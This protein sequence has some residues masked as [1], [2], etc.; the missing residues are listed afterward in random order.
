MLQNVFLTDNF[1]TEEKPQ[2]DSLEHWQKSLNNKEF[3]AK[4]LT[5]S[6]GNDLLHLNDSFATN[7]LNYGSLL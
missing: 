6:I 1:I 3:R 5:L 7:A 4:L 2:S